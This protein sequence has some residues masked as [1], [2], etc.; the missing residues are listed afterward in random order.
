MGAVKT[1]KK[2][3]EQLNVVLAFLIIRDDMVHDRVQRVQVQSRIHMPTPPSGIKAC[4][5]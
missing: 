5:L 3:K 4:V 1:E 2:W